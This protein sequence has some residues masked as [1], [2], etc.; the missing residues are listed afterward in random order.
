MA[1]GE[2][3]GRSGRWVG[4][5]VWAGV[6]QGRSN[7]V[8]AAT[9]LRGRDAGDGGLL[10]SAAVAGATRPRS[11]ALGAEALVLGLGVGLVARGAQGVACARLARDAHVDIDAAIG[12]KRPA[13]QAEL[14]R[15]GLAGVV[16]HLEACKVAAGLGAAVVVALAKARGGD[17]HACLLAAGVDLVEE[18][19]LHAGGRGSSEVGFRVVSGWGGAAVRV[20][21]G[22]EVAAVVAGLAP[23]RRRRP[24]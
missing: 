2:W 19:G 3:E 9:L 17:A 6:W 8:E 4:W 14:G 16:D 20:Q 22:A 24:G 10:G 5:A 11:C 7:L 18:F 12:A 21:G 23:R 15:V 13:Q 1:G